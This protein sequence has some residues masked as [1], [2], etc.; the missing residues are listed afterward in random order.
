MKTKLYISIILTF[1]F[2]NTIAQKNAK[3]IIDS[4]N[5]D[6]RI[7]KIQQNVQKFFI[8]QNKRF[9]KKLEGLNKEYIIY[10]TPTYERSGTLNI[11][12]T[13]NSV[14]PTSFQIQDSLPI[15]IP[16]YAKFL[17]DRS[18]TKWC[19]ERFG[20]ENLK[21]EDDFAI[22]F[23]FSPDNIPDSLSTLKIKSFNSD[24]YLKATPEKKYK[25]DLAY[26][27][28][29]YNILADGLNERFVRVVLKY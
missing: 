27:Q 10:C 1:L 9:K 12:S 6:T 7:E 19:K 20:Y 4:I 28:I 22:L 16:E 18:N 29:H 24:E 26:R 23:I 17:L 2:L 21:F 5:N 8:Q 13:G 3:E 15:Q 14:K 25:I 11:L